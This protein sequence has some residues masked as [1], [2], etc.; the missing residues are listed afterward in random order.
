MQIPFNEL[1]KQAKEDFLNFIENDIELCAEDCVFSLAKIPYEQLLEE[2]DLVLGP[3]LIDE[4]ENDYIKELAR[5]ISENGLINQ[6][7][8]SEGIHRSLA[9]LILK[10]DMLR[11]ELIQINID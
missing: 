11:F 8:C 2:L 6:P 3:N 10:R 1:P 7:I 5:D 9:H 4:L